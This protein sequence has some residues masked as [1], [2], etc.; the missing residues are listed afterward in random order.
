VL[1]NVRLALILQ[2]AL[3]LG[4]MRGGVGGGD[5]GRNGAARSSAEQAAAGHGSV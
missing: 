5:G 4:P 3:A 2:G 1:G